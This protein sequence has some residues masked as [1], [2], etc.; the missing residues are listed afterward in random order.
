MNFDDASASA[1][2]QAGFSTF[3]DQTVVPASSIRQIQC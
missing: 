1:M 2:S 3:V